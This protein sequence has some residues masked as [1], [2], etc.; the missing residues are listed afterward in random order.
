[1]LM[2]NLKLDYSIIYYVDADTDVHMFLVGSRTTKRGILHDFP[3]ESNL[4]TFD[5]ILKAKEPK[6]CI[7]YVPWNDFRVIRPSHT[8]FI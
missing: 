6:N 4:K 2:K 7:S 8:V 5:T 1:M 3:I